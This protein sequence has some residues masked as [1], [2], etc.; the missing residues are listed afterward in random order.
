MIFTIAWREFRSLFLSPLA[1][2]ILAVLQ[3]ILGILFFYIL[4]V[5]YGP[6]QD[7]YAL[8][9]GWPGATLIILPNFLTLAAFLLLLVVPLLTMRLISEERRAKTLTLLFSA[10]IS[11]TEIVLGKYLGV[12]LFLLLVLALVALMPL[13]LLLG[14][15]IDLGVVF[16]GLFGLALTLASFAA[17]GLFISTLTQHPTVAA[18]ASFG[19]LLCFWLLDVSVQGTG[20]VAYLSLFNHYQPFLQGVFDTADAA[21]HLLLIVTF[22]TLSVR[23]LDADRL[24]IA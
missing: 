10:P 20:L 11:M 12:M 24:G 7:K 13:S 8:M 18:I 15:R 6:N 21:Y 1:W 16:A 9:E 5:V 22:L 17:V 3:L 23:R 19:A 4:I 2:A 14:G